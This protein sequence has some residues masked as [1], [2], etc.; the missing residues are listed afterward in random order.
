[1]VIVDL[2]RKAAPQIVDEGGEPLLWTFDN[3]RGIADFPLGV[4]RV[5]T[6]RWSPDG[7]WI[8]F[9]KRVNGVNEVWRAFAD[10]S[11]SAPLTHSE[12]DVVD[13]A[14]G[15]GGSSI[16]YATR[17]DIERQQRENATEGLN[18]WHYDD[19]FVPLIAKR[20]L[21]RAPVARQA[22]V[23]D[24]ATGDVRAAR[25]EEAARVAADHQIIGSCWPTGSR[26][27]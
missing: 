24:L 27:E 5:I 13:F 18:G 10:G 9:L 2:T 1:M 19:R 4:M 20:P 17:P 7:R 3:F 14:I 8:A 26:G 11:G 6:P 16:I 15:E 22:T 12:L 23:L 25:P 21:P